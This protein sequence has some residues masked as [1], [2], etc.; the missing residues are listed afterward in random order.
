[1]NVTNTKSIDVKT[2]ELPS[3]VSSSKNGNKNFSDE[4][5]IVK[6]TEDVK[7]N[8]DTKNDKSANKDAEKQNDVKKAGNN[9]KAEKVDS[10]LNGLNDT[11]DELSKLTQKD[12]PQDELIKI[13]NYKTR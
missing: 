12:E 9:D 1:M 10:A 7:K 11:I 6:D 5:K 3:K 4:L 2:N 13:K 8:Q